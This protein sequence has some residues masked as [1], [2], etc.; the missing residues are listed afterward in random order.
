M[1]KVSLNPLDIVLE[2]GM[3]II[4]RVWPDPAKQ[5]EEARKLQELY[6]KG[7]L[8]ELEAYIRIIEGQLRVNEKEASHHSIFVA[9]W[10]PFIGWVGGAALA[11][12]FVVYP[13]LIWI[14][15]ILQA[16]GYVPKDLSP[17]PVL[18]TGALFSIVTGMLGVSISRSWEKSK[19]VSRESLKK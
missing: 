7:E 2:A 3:E 1:N 15:V 10:R 19:G 6:Q 14:W 8:A 11:Y 5:A 13:F 4:R 18:E 16:T 9:G 17:P 12:Q